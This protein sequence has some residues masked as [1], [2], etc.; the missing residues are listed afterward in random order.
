MENVNTWLSNRHTHTRL[1]FMAQYI[2]SIYKYHLSCRQLTAII[3]VLHMWRFFNTS[4]NIVIHTALHWIDCIAIDTIEKDAIQTN[5]QQ[6]R[7]QHTREKKRRLF[8]C[9]RLYFLSK[10]ETIPWNVQRANVFQFSVDHHILFVYWS[11]FSTIHSK[12]ASH[13]DVV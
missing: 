8:A 11:E 6:R 2:H 10:H 4:Q 13:Q 12:N 3:G 7:T 5:K 1:L 9:N